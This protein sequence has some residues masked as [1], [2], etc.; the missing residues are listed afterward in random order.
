MAAYI[1][2]RGF[3]TNFRFLLRYSYLSPFENRSLLCFEYVALWAK[4]KHA[5][6]D[7]SEWPD[8][9]SLWARPPC[10]HSINESLMNAA[11]HCRILT[12]L[13]D[14]GTRSKSDRKTFGFFNGHIWREAMDF[15]Q[16]R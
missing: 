13:P 6:S 10:Q 4:G 15:H 1:T 3:R 9:R 7:L 16:L 2:R 8:L 11:D 5:S 14:H 12:S